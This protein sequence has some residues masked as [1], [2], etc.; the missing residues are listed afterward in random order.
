MVYVS[1]C[2][3]D[4]ANGWVKES[5]GASMK[6]QDFPPD[7][8][9]YLR[10]TPVLDW[11]R[12]RVSAH[13]ERFREMG[14][15]VERAVALYLDARDGIRYDP[16]SPFYL[17]EHYRAGFVLERGRSF[18]IPKAALLCAFARG[19][20]IPSRLGFATVRNHLATRNLL[21]Y[22]GTNLFVFHG[23]TELYLDGKW[24]KATPAFNKELCERHGVPPLEFDGREDSLFQ[25]YNDENRKYMEYVEYTGVYDDVPVEGILRAWKEVYGAE[26]V[27]SWIRQLEARQGESGFRFEAEE[28]V[29]S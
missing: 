25:P 15:P 17:P 24:V 22:L 13:L 4:E 26:R 3:F 23:F 11:D 27:D 21:D 1:G 9:R 28:V 6:R 18:C 20:G 16:Y 10:P 2:V 29:S 7:F 8:Q 19:C 14:D 5:Q 12:P